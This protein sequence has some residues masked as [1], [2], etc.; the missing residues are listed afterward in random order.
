MI[1]PFEKPFYAKYHSNA[2][3]VGHP[4]LDAVDIHLSENEE[5]RSLRQRHHL[6]EKPMLH[7]W[8]TAPAFC[9]YRKAR[10]AVRT[11]YSHQIN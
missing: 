4:L 5:V 1:F 6:N 2:D 3:Y 9:T 8:R 10:T 7:S 11:Q